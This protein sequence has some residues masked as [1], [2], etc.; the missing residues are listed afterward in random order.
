MTADGQ[1]AVYVY[2]AWGVDYDAGLAVDGRDAHGAHGD[3]VFGSH[4]FS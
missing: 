4:S 3:D 1:Q 2:H